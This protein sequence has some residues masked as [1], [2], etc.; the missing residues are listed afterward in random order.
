MLVEDIETSFPGPLR[1]SG[2]R[3]GG[4]EECQGEGKREERERKVA[5]MARLWS[6]EAQTPC[7]PGGY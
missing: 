3:K 7:R 5:L 1:R 4:E 6:R 2:R